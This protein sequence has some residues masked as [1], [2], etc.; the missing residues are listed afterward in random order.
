MKQAQYKTLLINKYL[1]I[2]K[3]NYW[4]LSDE[5]FKLFADT[6]IT[7]KSGETVLNLWEKYLK[8][9]DM[10]VKGFFEFCLDVYMENQGE[11]SD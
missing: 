11:V 2:T 5:D 10:D 8:G 3:S 9:G 7:F 6:A 4:V 1:E